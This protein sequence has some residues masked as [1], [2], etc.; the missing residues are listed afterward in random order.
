MVDVVVNHNAW[1]GTQ[2]N[3]DYT[4]FNPFNSAS[5]YHAPCYIDYNNDTSIVDCWLGDNIVP[6]V[7]LKTESTNVAEGYQTWIKELVSN[8]SSMPSLTVMGLILF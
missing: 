4:T 3:V 7:D 5:D 6:L 8:Y 1:I 2:T